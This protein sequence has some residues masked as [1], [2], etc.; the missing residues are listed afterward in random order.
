MTSNPGEEGVG[1]F[2]VDDEAGVDAERGD[3]TAG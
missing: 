3:L 1:R 2:V